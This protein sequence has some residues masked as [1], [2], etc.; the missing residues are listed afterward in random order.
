M[1]VMFG[2]VALT[3]DTS[4][5]ISQVTIGGAYDNNETL[6]FTLIGSKSLETAGDFQLGTRRVLLTSLSYHQ[7]QE[8]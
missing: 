2:S 1:K 8:L 4:S 5:N 7:Q 3:P 6:S